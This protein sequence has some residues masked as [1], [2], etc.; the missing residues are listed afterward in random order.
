MSIPRIPVNGNLN[1][2]TINEN[3][4]LTNGKKIGDFAI[5]EACINPPTV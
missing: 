5:F 1:G 2:E 4:V 3:V